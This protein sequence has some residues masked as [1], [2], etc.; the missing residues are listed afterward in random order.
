MGVVPNSWKGV[1]Q[2]GDD[3]NSST[4]NR[5]IIGARYYLKGFEAE[6][7]PVNRMFESRSARDMLAHGSLTS[8]IVVG[9][10][11]D[12]VSSP[13]GFARGTATGGAPLIR[14]AIYKVIWKIGE[15]DTV[16]VP[17]DS[18]AAVDDAIHIL[19]ISY[20]YSNH[21]TPLNQDLVSVVALYAAKA[22]VVVAASAGNDGPKPA[23]AI[24]TAPWL[25]TMGSSIID[26]KFSSDIVLGTGLTVSEIVKPMGTLLLYAAVIPATKITPTKTVLGA[27]PAPIANDFSSRGPNAATPFILKPDITA[28]GYYILG[29][30]SGASRKYGDV[31]YG[32]LSGT[33]M[34][35]PHVAGAMA[36]LK[37]VHRDWSSAA[38]RSALMTTAG[39]LNNEG[40]PITTDY[41]DTTT[42][43]MIGSGYFNP[44]KAVDPGLVYDASFNDYHLFLCSIGIHNLSS[45]KCLDNPPPPYNLNYPSLAIPD[46][47]GTVTVVRTVTN[48]GCGKGV[49]YFSKVQSP[50]GIL[51]NIQPPVL[52]FDRAGEKK[53]FTITVKTDSAFSG[54]IGKGE[55]LFGGEY[56]APGVNILAAWSEAISP[57]R[58]PEDRRIVKYN[59]KSGTSMLCPH[60]TGAL[61]L[62][63]AV[64][65]NWSSA[66][67]RS[68]L[69]TTSIY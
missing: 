14:L 21:P 22:N 12:N 63:K 29:A 62:L 8:S 18:L 25:I 69:M 28:S 50:K 60:V 17:A 23:T 3:F 38:L 16:I 64:H 59:I 66:A 47:K 9:R 5:K 32:F 65:P 15:Y 49:Y 58:M 6:Y 48:V 2:L 30:W 11:V 33:S 44:T 13:Y 43:F 19:S 35:C 46:L 41:N 51:V 39:Q 55:Y 68:A 36:L 20:G 37:A 42:P 34:S 10:Q 31:K 45:T 67:L 27:K 61:A 40:N 4:C 24:N 26:G 54:T 56:A 1:C 53:S 52:K 57:T 7:G